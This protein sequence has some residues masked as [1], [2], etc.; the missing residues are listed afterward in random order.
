MSGATRSDGAVRTALSAILIVATI[1]SARAS[2]Q[3]VR[4]GPAR[5]IDS[6]DT[7][8][9]LDAGYDPVNRV[10]L[11]VLPKEEGSGTSGSV[12][13]V[14]LD[15]AGVPV[16]PPFAIHTGGRANFARVTYSAHVSNGAGGQGGFLVTWTE[17]F[18]PAVSSRIVAYP[19]RVGGL[20]LLGTEY[21]LREASYSN[22]SQR[23]L[24]TAH[25]HELRDT[26][27][28]RGPRWWHVL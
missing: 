1:L 6:G 13:G 16:Q 2:A 3:L 5:P 25:A 27:S 28:V 24:L 12:W 10:Y 21:S 20:R 22:T 14:F 8:F 4:L 9:G 17:P 15:A 18:T 26:G 11:A 7:V 19:N 23:F